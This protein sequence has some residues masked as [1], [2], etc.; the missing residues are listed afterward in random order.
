MKPASVRV[1]LIWMPQTGVPEGGARTQLWNMI[2][3]HAVLTR[4]PRWLWLAWKEVAYKELLSCDQ[5]TLGLLAACCRNIE[6]WACMSRHLRDNVVC[7]ELGHTTGIHTEARHPAQE[8]GNWYQGL[9][10]ATQTGPH[11]PT[12]YPP[13]GVSSTPPAPGSG[14][15]LLRGDHP[16]HYL[17][18]HPCEDTA[19]A[20]FPNARGR[21]GGHL[22]Q[23]RPKQRAS[24]F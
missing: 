2:C 18:P 8:I 5:T 21:Q 10:G 9:L 6:S 13:L 24:T 3:L 17:Q 19:S 1:A 23:W 14:H 15:A 7:P 12:T 20:S 16:G 22:P 4:P 11:P